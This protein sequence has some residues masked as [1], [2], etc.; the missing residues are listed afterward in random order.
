MK[1]FRITIIVLGFFFFATS[2]LKAQTTQVVVVDSAAQQ[3]PNLKFGLGFGLNFVG[4]TNISLSP[5]LVYIVSDRVNIGA[6]LQGS[7][8]A[9]KDLQKTTTIGGN[10]MLQ[11]NPSPR[12]TTLAEVVLLNVDTT[13]ELD[14]TKENFWDTAL[15][16]GAGL[17]ITNKILVGAKYNLLY[18]EDESVYTSPVIPFVNIVF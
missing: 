10:T 4:G 9:I 3:E 17:K 5:N 16:I 11:Y 14:D 13:F 18:D 12:F 15:F 1:S 6:G 2:P 8:T 7:Y